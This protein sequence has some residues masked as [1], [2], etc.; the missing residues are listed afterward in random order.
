MLSPERLHFLTVNS[1]PLLNIAKQFTDRCV[2]VLLCFISMVVCI[3]LSSC[4]S[5]KTDPI[6]LYANHELLDAGIFKPGTYWVYINDSTGANDSVVVTAFDFLP[7]TI[8][9]DCKGDPVNVNY[10]ESYYTYS[11]SF[12]YGENYVTTA[13]IGDV[14][15]WGKISEPADTIFSTASCK[16]AGYCALIDTM[17]VFH[18]KYTQVYKRIDS[19]SAI[20]DGRLAQFYSAP[21]FGLI[22]KEILRPDGTWETWNLTHAVIVQ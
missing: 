18:K 5:C 3:S 8:R 20:Y 21:H 4:D 17:Q 13:Q 9:E 6:L 22:R 11:T 12:L 2:T 7:D 16:D 19:S 14:L 10:K 1:L 15:L